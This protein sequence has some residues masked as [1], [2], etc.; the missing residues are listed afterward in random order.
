MYRLVDCGTWD[1]PWFEAL[2]P[3]G[4]L[5]FL[6][7]L[8]NPRSTSCGAFE[9]TPRKMAFETG[10]SQDFIEKMLRSWAPRVQWW[11]E[12][13]IVFLKN[14]YRRQSNSAKVRINA[15]K[16]VA[17]MPSVVR[18]AIYMEYP[19]FLPGADTLSIPY[20][21]AT[22]KQNRDVTETETKQDGTERGKGADAPPKRA[23][24]TKRRTQ[25]P[26]DFTLDDELLAWT[27]ERGWDGA[28]V[29][30]ELE[31]F[32]GHHQKLGN[33]MADWAAAWRTWVLKGLEIDDERP[34]MPNGRASPTP[35][36]RSRGENPHRFL[37]LTN[38]PT[39]RSVDR[40]A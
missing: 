13:Q 6:Y 12:H 18:D 37:A 26:D 23:K 28:R 7:L 38:A 8:T 30:T 20:A 34:R 11:P 27:Y 19:E 10:L 2:A 25:I 15:A 1:D 16:L 5:L 14:F 24:T 40:D 9:I 39:S 17:D 4:K 29:H 36:P 31:K 35:P 32:R 22:D 3:Q 21:D 33:L